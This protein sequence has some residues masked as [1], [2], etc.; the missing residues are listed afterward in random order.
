MKENMGQ[1]DG[2][3]NRK[4]MNMFKSDRKNCDKMKI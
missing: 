1:R 4:A 3:F 2:H